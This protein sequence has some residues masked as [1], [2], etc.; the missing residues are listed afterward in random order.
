MISIAVCTHNRSQSLKR[1]L[2][3]LRCTS[4]PVD[5]DWELVV[6]DNNSTDDTRNIANEFGRLSALPGRYI[7]EPRQ[8]LAYARNRAMSAAAGDIIVFTDDDC[9][10]DRHWLVAVHEEFSSEPSLSYLGGR[11]ELYNRDDRPVSIRTDRERILFDSPGQLFSL[12]PGC[13]MAFRRD[14]YERIGDFDVRLGAG[15]TIPGADDSD[16]I[17]R[18]YKA[19]FKLAYSPNVL[20]YHDHGRNSDDQVRQLNRG[21]VIGRG[22]FYCKHIFAGDR[23]ILKCAY[24]E[25]NGLVRRLFGNLFRGRSAADELRMLWHLLLGAAYW[26]RAF[27]GTNT[28]R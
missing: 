23:A 16:F 13:N 12:I 22:A 4:I 2:E 9:I 28:A 17:Y 6:V 11:V 21:Y 26:L 7:F 3:S 25:V 14:V 20:V 18:A 24:W 8:G 19:G 1:L 15:T 27:I 10:V 5:F